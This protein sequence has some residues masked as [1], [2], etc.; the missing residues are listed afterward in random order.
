MSEPI[1]I[2]GT[3]C[4]FPGGAD[5]P[6]K[7]WSLLQRPRDLSSKPP[8]NRFNIEPFY[9][10]VGTHSGTTNA[11]KSY[12][13]ENDITRFDANFFNI[14]PAEA[15][16]MDP[17]QRIL[18]EV[19]YDGLCA[20]GQPINSLRGSDTAVYVG[21]MS[22][23]YNYV[24]NRDWLTLPRYA[25]TGIERA[26]VANRIS[27]YFDWHG[28]SMS[29]DT[30]CSSSL[31]ALDQAVQTL[32]SGK[33]KMAVAA[34]TNL[35]LSPAVL[36][37]ESNLGM[38]SPAGR[39][40]M[41]DDAADGYA[42]G[43]GVAVV[44]LKTLSQ[45]LAD[46][47]PIEC[48][49]RETAVNQDGH[50]APGL[51]IP[52]NITQAALIRECYARAGLD[53]INNIVDRPQFFQAHGTGT[54]AGDPQEAGAIARALFPAT[55]EVGKLLVGSIKTIIGHTEGT[56]G[57]ASVIATSLALKH[58]VIPPNLHFQTLNPKI[59]PFYEN[60][61]IPTAA[62]P[63]P[64]TVD[65][66]VRRA[67]VNSF[68]FGGTNAHCILEQHI[69]E[70]QSAPPGQ[71]L[72]TPLIF[73]ATSEWSLRAMLSDHLE[74][75][76]ANPGVNL[77]DF[78]YTAQERRTT[79]NYRAYIASPTIEEAIKSLDGLVVSQ[80]DLGIRSGANKAKP[81]VLGIFTG[82]GAQW[83]RMGAR[84]IELSSFAACRVDEM[85]EALRTI[86]NAAERPSWTLKEQLLAGK[87]TSRITEAA[88]SQPLCTLVQILL[89]DI[90]RSAGV[91]F[92]AVV[93][94]SSGEIGAAY[95]SGLVSARDAILIAYFRGLHAKLA[96]SPFH[97][98]SRGAMMAVGTS[99]DLATA[100]CEER[101]AGRLQVAAVNST[102]SITLSGD[103][104]IVDEAVATL[105][106]QG[107][108]ARKLQ[109]DT[110]YH[111][112]HM[113]TCAA[114]YLA[115]LEG[116]GVQ[117]LA[118]TSQEFSSTLWYS[119]VYEGK[120]MQG[121]DLKNQYWVENMCKPVLFSGALA[122]A[123]ETSGSFDLAVEVGP[124]PALKGP[125]LA[126]VSADCPYTGL[127]ARD[128]D[129][130]EQLSA[131]FGYIWARL[132]DESVHFTAVQAL[133]SGR[134][135]HDEW[136]VITDLPPYPFD[137]RQTFWHD[138]RVAN[139]YKHRAEREVP[140]PVLGMPCS[141]AL[142]PGEFQWRNV[143]RPSEM[144]WLRGHMLQGQLVFPATAYVSMAIEAINSLHLAHD[145]GRDVA[146]NISM[147]KL[148]NVEIPSAITF[149]DDSASVETIFSVS[150]VS[151]VDGRLMADWA[152]YSV[153]EGRGTRIVLN[154]K[155][156]AQAQLSRPEP[157]AL[158][159]AKDSAYNLAH[160]PEAYFYENL[161]LIGY[162]YSPPFRGLSNITRKPGY[163]AGKLVDQS[164]SAWY[165]D[166][167]LHPGML[168]SALQTIFAAWSFP[169]D[170]R[171]CSL[172]MP[173][174]V[175]T[176]T[177]NTFF[178]SLGDGG[179][180]SRVSYKSTVRSQESSKIVGD[181]YLDTEESEH[182]QGFIQLEGVS[183][184]PFSRATAKD[185]EPMFSRL[186]YA[187]S[188]PDGE[189]ASAGELLSAYQVQLYKDVDRIS[190][191]YIR[192]A[193]AAIPAEERFN[194]LP[195]YQHYLAWCDR[196]VDI[197]SSGK[198]E[199]VPDSCNND[200]SKEIDPLLARY[201]D[202]KDV[203]FVQVVG[204]N[205]VDAI[206]EG[207]SMV[208][209]MDQNGLLRAFFAEDA[210]FY[211]PTFRWIA[212]IMGQI[213]HRFPGA[214]ILEIGAG[215][216]TT[217]GAVLETKF[218]GYSSSTFTDVST[219]LFLPDDE[220]S[221]EKANRMA[222]KTFDMDQEPS[223]QGFSERSHDVVVA[224]NV[225]HTSVDVKG[226]LANVRKLLKPGGF[227]VVAELT[228]TDL[229]FSGMT[230]GTL[231]DWW[232][233]AD[234]DRPW[235]PLLALPQW[236]ATLRE[237]GFSGIDTVTSDI[238][239]SLPTNVF[240]AQAI[241]D[242][243][244]LL[245]EPLAAAGLPPGIWTD[246][247]AII[248]GI[249]E[250]IQEL[251]WQIYA[252][253]GCRFRRKEVFRTVEDYACSA[254]AQSSS[255]DGSVAVLC[256]TDL[257]RPYLE[258]LTNSRFEALKTL[259]TTAG[260]VVWTT[261]GSRDSN[262][263]SYMMNGII[264]TV[265]NEYPDLNVQVFDLDDKFGI[266]PDTA[267]VL[268]EALLR[269]LMLHTWGTDTGAF[270]W[271]AEPEI[272]VENGRQLITR[273]QPDHEKNLRY[274]SHRRD[275]MKPVNTAKDTI[276]LAGVQDL[277]F[278]LQDVSPLELIRPPGSLAEYRTIRITHSLLQ[279]V[280]VGHYGFFRVC[281]GVDVE[282]AEVVLALSGCASSPASIPAPCCLPIANAP[283]ASALVSVAS[284]LVAEQ[285]LA[286]APA[287][288]TLL[289]NESHPQVRLAILAKANRK[290]VSARFTS[291]RP[292]RDRGLKGLDGSE[293]V[294]LHPDN[295]RHLIQEVVPANTA[296]FV[297][298][299]RG[300]R[301]EALRVAISKFLP[302]S[303]LR[304]SEEAL[305]SSTV[306]CGMTTG[307]TTD[308]AVATV[309]AL[310]LRNAWYDSGEG[311]GSV[312]LS[313]T[314]DSSIALGDV[315][316]R[317]A[318]REGL[319]V[320]DWNADQVDV[321]VQPIDSGILFGADKTYVFIGMATEL[322]QSLAGWMMAHGARH[323]VLTS[324][325]PRVNPRFI[326][327]MES[328]YPGAVVKAM[329]VDVTSGES[330]RAMKDTIMA[331]LPSI[332]GIV[333]GA[334]VLDDRLF[335]NMSYEQFEKV[336]KPKVL[337]TQL[338]DD[339]FHDDSS[340]DFFIVASSITAVIGWTGQSNYSAA[341]NF[342]TSLV[343]NRRDR[344]GVVG[345]AM[346]IP[347]VKGV[348]FAAREESGFDFDYFKY[349]GYINSSE[350]DFHTLFAEAI[351]SGRPDN[352][353]RG[354][355]EVV[356]GINYLPADVEVIAAH[357]RDVKFCHFIKRED[358]K[359]ASQSSS[360]GR[361]MQVKAQL[362]SA[363]NTEAARAIV[364]AGFLAQLKRVLRLPEESE[365][366]ESTTLVELGVDSLVAV[367]MR[368]WFLKE[369]GVNVP[370]LKILGGGSISDL[371]D[372]VMEGLATVVVS[373]TGIPE[374]N[375]PKASD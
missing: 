128:R 334:M 164:S 370:T 322:G 125:A 19:V 174:S 182:P 45:A 95:A 286:L 32:R 362:E 276:R 358:G 215:I 222:F 340:L 254:M 16:A 107:T 27:Y 356:M 166:L 184:V 6:S 136:R 236:D 130:V 268:V 12:W 256:V 369:V 231:P 185:D 170:G 207:Q 203:R 39:C 277:S 240:V 304:I 31:V 303:C 84:L 355:A 75:L 220:R 335:A 360:K 81:K 257:D 148:T 191:W 230:L 354:P 310:M 261:S 77:E 227:L 238:S 71:V 226:S 89:V 13:L 323:I 214:N 280:A 106:A 93:G 120:V 187:V 175:D 109:V 367:D 205:L 100:F 3:A 140:N 199:K 42:R 315:V 63:W 250:P 324:R 141:E 52:S 209:H 70:S 309:V 210:L 246:A 353:A 314:E 217:T 282:T 338:L 156:K 305:L 189:Q 295:P 176:I 294:F 119:S 154:A 33:S 345:S 320:V 57:I 47:D 329:S 115:S 225:L 137:H 233:G 348:G 44:L 88:L 38:L 228:S 64:R 206:R 252:A 14:Q 266:Q 111:S 10:P 51:T 90:L 23:D 25:A 251:A 372:T 142:T 242:K 74:Y 36:I 357:R 155:G 41:W 272:F 1:A 359:V 21:Q 264:R 234:T 4:R 312:S 308:A 288:S 289:V 131:A 113:T 56:A 249:T 163:S 178:T 153:P 365:L 112:A 99:L 202:R 53:P 195:H 55:G 72:F 232:I 284:N 307:C 145:Y 101:F 281:A 20:S 11:S 321:K 201:S 332:G 161:S 245:R 103:A 59:T 82:Q 192:N 237:A 248:G 135:K 218:Q 186:T 86:P 366:D 147:L 91:S 292:A 224:V 375:Q 216:G 102:S 35:I 263:F 265:T 5:T 319:A 260:T 30:A 76:K 298:F 273:V 143:L 269:Q 68:G 333:N 229:L 22:D 162:D 253:V 316:D 168:D 122:S 311:G 347:A 301:S 110:A 165:D 78:A 139:Q 132:G 179:N 330:L 9:N 66:Q 177:I 124:H 197:I 374:N 60:L 291:S 134:L 368:A 200:T 62:K 285:I 351:L 46:N 73:S 85:D 18:L 274:N 50:A 117:P 279:S 8:S 317:T 37:S 212:R 318:V 15:E 343:C 196:M 40:A 123:V 352:K 126:A 204:D 24:L 98:A 306:G 326:A 247:L 267:L 364:S 331:T 300:A 133:L 278:E 173:V 26:I 58:G 149:N 342:M 211:G 194:L 188:K 43:E 116:C 336:A 97:H 235:G 152:C 69:P 346:V 283:S 259:W 160:V 337:G 193:A 17:Q 158:P 61:M 339:L 114:P 297:H 373:E 80:A 34:G 144:P 54:Q 181:I 270:L 65:G 244:N 363:Q 104:D 146:V 219:S 169:G 151:R 171:I 172:Y 271:T 258:T 223:A 105:K 157:N 287:G 262:H 299:S 83:P 325:N 371:V 2:I 241:D 349:L 7:L 190:Y 361:V 159:P 293:P 198:S 67:S 239:A 344:R 48:V 243:V 118:K 180:E 121:E 302:A 213:S 327:D 79:L 296:V 127:L 255:I 350:E 138:S 183:F 87:D 150:S 29:V 328:K 275:V 208:D 290:R 108:F 341:N 221:V 92:H 167:I 96:A 129:D 49:I 28:P 313:T 94:H